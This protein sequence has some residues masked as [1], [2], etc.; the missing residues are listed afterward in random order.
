VHE[1][2]RKHLLQAVNELELIMKKKARTH[3][4]ARDESNW[5]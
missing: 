5:E 3:P 4:K 1:D 2:I